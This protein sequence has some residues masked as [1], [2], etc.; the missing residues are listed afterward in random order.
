MC[1]WQKKESQCGC[2]LLLEGRQ[3]WE[4]MEEAG[5]A[6]A[7]QGLVDH[8]KKSGFVLRA[9][10]SQWVVLNAAGGGGIRVKHPRICIII[11]F[12]LENITLA[13][14]W[15]TSGQRRPVRTCWDPPGRTWQGWDYS[16]W[17]KASSTPGALHGPE[18][19]AAFIPFILL[20]ILIW[21]LY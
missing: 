18:T 7:M 12:A 11:G 16:R 19:L 17:C 8:G 20:K 15:K 4:E 14:V 13:T 1:L 3:V 10:W 21:C 2:R 6:Q 5:R 9:K